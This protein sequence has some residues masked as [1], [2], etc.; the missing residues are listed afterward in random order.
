ML[1]VKLTILPQCRITTFYSINESNVKGELSI[2]NK[3]NYV[4]SGI[5]GEGINVSCT[6]GNCAMKVWFRSILLFSPCHLPIANHCHV[7]L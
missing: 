1:M 7:L 4:T 2:G 5:L 3:I 6:R